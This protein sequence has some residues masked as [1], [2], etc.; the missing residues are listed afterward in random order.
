MLNI[1]KKIFKK[2]EEPKEIKQEENLIEEVLV[3]TEEKIIKNKIKETVS[4]TI[5]HTKSDLKSGL[6]G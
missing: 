4:E 6:G 2:K 3:L 5:S 1:I